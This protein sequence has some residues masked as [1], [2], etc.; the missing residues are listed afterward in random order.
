[1]FPSF[2]AILSSLLEFFIKFIRLFLGATAVL[3]SI[4]LK[5]IYEYFSILQNFFITY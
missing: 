3:P 1:M 4:L 2:D 5:Q